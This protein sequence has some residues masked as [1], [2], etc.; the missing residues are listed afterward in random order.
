[1][2]YCETWDNSLNGYIF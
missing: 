2:Y 1:E